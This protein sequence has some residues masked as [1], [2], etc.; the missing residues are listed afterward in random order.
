M[1]RGM[2]EIPGVTVVNQPELNQFM[3]RFGEDRGPEA[4]DRLTAATVAQIQRDAVAF[5]GTARWRGRLVMRVSVSS[6][7]TTEADAELT[8]AAVGAAWEAVRGSNG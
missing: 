7:E 6:I 2:A 1:A 5:M 3:V 8:V 4:G